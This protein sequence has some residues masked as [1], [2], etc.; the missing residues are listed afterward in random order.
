MSYGAQVSL[1]SDS[2][3]TEFP[4]LFAG[5]PSLSA[6]WGVAHKGRS[7][8]VL[9]RLTARKT[10]PADKRPFVVDLARSRGCILV[11]IDSPPRAL[12]DAAGQSATV[13]LGPDAGLKSVM[14]LRSEIL[15]P[16]F[17]PLAYS[18]VDGA[19]DV[20]RAF[21]GLLR[22]QSG[23]SHV[24]IAGSGAEA[25]ETAILACQRRFPKR[26]KVVAF[27]GSFHGRTLLALH[28]THNPAKREP[29]DFY[30]S[31]IEFLPFPDVPN[32]R[33][34]AF[35]ENDPALLARE[36]ACLQRLHD[37]C[38]TEAPLCLVVEPMQAEGGDRYAR[39]QFFARL[40][41]VLGQYN[42][43]WILDE[44]QTGFG[45]GGPFFWFQKWNLPKLPDY[46]CVAKKAQVGAVLSHE[47]V[48]LRTTTSA[49]SIYR[50]Y[51]QGLTVLRT[52]WREMEAKIWSRLEV[53]EH[54]APAK[55]FANPRGAAYAFSFDCESPEALGTLLKARETSGLFFLQAGPRTARFRIQ[56]DVSDLE[57]DFLFQKLREIMGL[58]PAT[59]SLNLPAA[60]PALDPSWIPKT[61]QAY[62]AT[63]ASTWD[64]VFRAIIRAH[65]L[66][67]KSESNVRTPLNNLFAKSAEDLWDEYETGALPLLDFLWLSSRRFGLKFIQLDRQ[68]IEHLKGP[69]WDLECAAYEPERRD[70]PET[71][72]ELAKDDKT[73]FIAAFSQTGELAGISCAVR[74]VHF[75][76]KV[77]LVGRDPARNEPDA[78]Y[79]MD[80]SIHPKF[81]GQGVGLRM[82]CEQI[83]AC[84]AQGATVLRSRNRVPEAQAMVN[85]N[86]SLGGVVIDVDHQAYG[87]NGTA[88]YQSVPIRGLMPHRIPHPADP[89]MGPLKHKLVHWWLMSEAFESA[90]AVLK[91]HVP[92]RYQHF[93]VTSGRAE[94]ADKMVKILRSKRPQATRAISF[95]GD[96]FGESTAVART[97]GGTGPVYFDDWICEA[98]DSGVLKRLDAVVSKA[99]AG[100]FL[101]VFIQASR[102]ES[103]FLKGLLAWA[104][105]HGLPVVF[106][107]T[108]T[109][110][111]RAHRRQFFL[112]Q[113]GL[114][115]DA[116]LFAPGGQLGIV[117]VT[118]EV[119][120]DKPLTMISTWDGDEHSLNLLRERLNACNT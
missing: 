23:F 19:W 89:E 50:G 107:E 82:K 88:L 16:E 102:H 92:E 4:E 25:I 5:R 17:D 87:G 7:H 115:P 53:L 2:D 110:F 14:A 83:L 30:K 78:I 80:I 36:D 62:Q 13:A 108:D 91:D 60:P 70:T 106:E 98:A 75:E 15:S 39:P 100:A 43:P 61:F 20:R 48:S 10:V 52:D 74:P 22:E 51:L 67:L 84:H 64:K 56:C 101:G 11:S 113:P 112:A 63:P 41:E 96:F 103:S 18:G 120:F 9:N 65:P 6:Q 26:R 81:Q 117:A 44:V 118:E 32:C 58:A 97:L 73:I 37:L 79:S 69:I 94:M 104:K 109:A 45:L 42:V 55:F 24:T 54:E 12:L 71:F 33:R 85:L 95:R 47:A 77:A 66:I 59:E 76:R 72:L 31:Q 93:Y 40:Q 8:D 49:A 116:I 1:T 34:E 21:E 46:V 68:G 105:N 99:G 29:Y 114:E 57:L 119:F 111:Y 38:K 27:D 28:A 86:V 90:I 35:P 3:I